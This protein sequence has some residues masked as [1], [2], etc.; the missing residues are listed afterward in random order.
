MAYN[1]TYDASD[2]STIT[3]DG[4]A[5]VFAVIVSLATLVGLVL[6]FAWFKKNVK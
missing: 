2:L 3:V 4:I 1:S 5:S 6:L